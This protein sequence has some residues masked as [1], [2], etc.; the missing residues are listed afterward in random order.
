MGHLVYLALYVYV[1]RG[2]LLMGHSCFKQTK[3][4]AMMVPYTL[5]K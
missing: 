3:Y 1:G 5:L 4:Y 2:T